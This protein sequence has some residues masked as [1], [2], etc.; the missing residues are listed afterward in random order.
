MSFPEFAFLPRKFKIAVCGSASD[1]AAIH[2][3]DIGM[4]FLEGGIHTN[5]GKLTETEQSEMQRHV[6][7][8]Y[9][10]LIR[11]PGWEEA[12]LIVL[13]HHERPDGQGYPNKLTQPLIHPGARILAIV[14][15]FFSMIHARADRPQK[16]S[17]TRA[18]AE[19]NV[20][21]GSQFDPMWVEAFNEVMKDEMRSGVF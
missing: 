17:V 19:I 15:A 2:M 8:G 1:R 4:S 21:S 5:S 14:D 9:D 18:M 12:A 13:N 10:I 20:R 16:K 6:A 3:H 11:T 7:W